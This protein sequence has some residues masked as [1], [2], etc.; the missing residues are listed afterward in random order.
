MDR[1]IDLSHPISPQIPVYPGDAG[2]DID[3][4]DVA[5]EPSANAPRSMNNSRLS[6]G[7]HN[8]TH[9]DAPFHFFSQRDTIDQIAI[10]RT[11]GPAAVLD[12]SRT[13]QE[14]VIDAQDLRPLA[15]QVTGKTIV[16]LA[17]G[18]DRHWNRPGYFDRH[19]VMTRSAAEEI[20]AWN[21]SAVGVDFPSVD[22]EPFE[23][24]LQ[25]LGHD[26]LIVENLTRLD[27]LIGRE[28]EFFAVPLAVV[29]RDASPVRA[30]ARYG[31]D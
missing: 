17:S 11:C 28:F 1:T 18:W 6:I 29:G 2:V 27:Q 23:A 13:R 31:S 21:V 4:V 3:V 10:A 12:V 8:G 30:F 26:V 20:V 7:L 16:L 14:G 22:R 19:P 15:S 24:H 5:R 25:L 9:I